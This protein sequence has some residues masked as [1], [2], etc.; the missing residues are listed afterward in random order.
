MMAKAHSFDHFD[1]SP[2][3]LRGALEAAELRSGPGRSILT[4]SSWTAMAI[5]CGMSVEPSMRS[6][7]VHSQ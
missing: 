4:I 1:W 2:D 3:E 6:L 5:R 7:R